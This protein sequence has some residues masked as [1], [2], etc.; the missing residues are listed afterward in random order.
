MIVHDEP[1]SFYVDLINSGKN[2]KFLKFGDGEFYCI[3]GEAFKSKEFEVTSE[4]TFDYRQIINNLRPH[5][6]NALQPL[7]T[8][9]P[10]LHHLV[11]PGIEWYNA[12]V[13]HKA[14][15]AGELE[16][17]FD[18]LQEKNVVLVCNEY[19]SGVAK[20]F[21]NCHHQIIISDKNCYPD[22]DYVMGQIDEFQVDTVFLLS[23]SVLSEYIIYHSREDCTFI[24]A[25]SIF[26]PFMG[27]A[28]R[29]YHHKMS[30]ET[31]KKNLGKYYDKF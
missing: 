2:F 13:F 24:D 11:P 29:S 1:L 31:I 8:R 22:K 25:G 19:M 3:R 9:T 4:I 30:E 20:Y 10:E 27:R 28:I 14:S 21:A 17:F 15:I 7:V 5:H 26:E 12:D 6:L 16:P 18:C 23:A